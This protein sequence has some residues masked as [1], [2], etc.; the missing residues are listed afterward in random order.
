MTQTPSDTT[1][2]RIALL[3]ELPAD[4][5]HLVGMVALR[6]LLKGLLRSYGLK[7][8]DIKES[9]T[10]TFRTACEQPDDPTEPSTIPTRE[11]R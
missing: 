9:D 3:L 2:R 5:P 1:K 11:T 4:N 6:R 7:C 8:I 10:G